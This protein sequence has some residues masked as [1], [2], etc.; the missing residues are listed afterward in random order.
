[1]SVVETQDDPTKVAEPTTD[2]SS[3]STEGSPSAKETDDKGKAGDGQ[4]EKP[5]TSRESVSP[6]DDEEDPKPDKDN[7]V[8]LR[9]EQFQRMKKR[10]QEHVQVMDELKKHGIESPEHAEAL[11]R[12]AQRIHNVE[13]TLA[14]D[15][16]GFEKDLYKSNPQAHGVIASNIHV[17]ASLSRAAFWRSQ[18]EEEKAK[19]LEDE[20][21][22]FRGGGSTASA[23]S[24]TEP[25]ADEDST[26]REKMDFFNDQV[27]TETTSALSSKINTLIQSQNVAF[28]D[29]SHKSKFVKRVMQGVTELMESDA[30]YRRQRDQAQNPNRGLGKDQRREAVE[31]NTKY[32]TLNGR[33]E[34]AFKEEMS[35]MNLGNGEPKKTIP[36]RKEINAPGS[37][38]GGELT[39]DEKNRIYQ[40]LANKGYT[41]SD[42]TAR[43]MGELR[44]RRSA[45]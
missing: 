17:R 34:K 16:L 1:M 15:P 12:D 8:A 30:I 7:R 32:A 43:Y 26:L 45:S 40:E 33:L 6:D 28:K 13:D 22:F 4:G 36:E 41:G 31:L 14:S 21:N 39:S 10:H 25:S 27:E 29:D 38:P 24:N 11:A 42:L 35:L 3:K 9:L 44:K 19:I 18:G 20:A 23:R 2:D 37:A 5:K